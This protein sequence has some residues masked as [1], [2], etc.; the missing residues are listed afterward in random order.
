VAYRVIYDVYDKELRVL[1]V[2]I[3]HRSDVYD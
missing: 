2:K 1:I 3:G